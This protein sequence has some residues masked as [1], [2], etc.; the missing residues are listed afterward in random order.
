MNTAVK[1]TPNKLKLFIALA[2]ICLVFYLI[3]PVLPPII[4]A[5]AIAYLLDPIADFWEEHGWN[6]PM[7]VV[8]T[9]GLFILLTVAIMA[10]VIPFM[11]DQWLLIQDKL[12]DV[13][14]SIKSWV[15]NPQLTKFYTQYQEDIQ[16][17]LINNA[18]L[19]G[20]QV[21]NMLKET[22]GSVF[23]VTLSILNLVI[24][25]VLAIYLLHDFDRL[26]I[27]FLG[28][29]PPK[30]KTEISD[31]AQEIHLSMMG[32]IKA[33]LSVA[34]SLTV[35]YGIGL[36]ICGVPGGL[37]IAFIA[38]MANLIPYLGLVIGIVPA[39]LL[40][41]VASPGWIVPLGVLATFG[42]GQFL[43]GFFITPHYMKKSVNLHPLTVLISLMIWGH[44]L[45]L[46][47]MVLALPITVA[48]RVFWERGWILIQKT[49]LYKK[50]KGAKDEPIA[51]TED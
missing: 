42:I 23:R 3:A 18:S 14:S 36:T 27:D 8:A 9:I 51:T 21:L 31:I 39:L 33:Q 17:F 28:F 40:G 5:L 13:Q 6:R 47:G 35:I 48:L 12:P 10:Y 19:I 34:S 49:D 32:F 41:Y 22:F 29:M 30:W 37:L 44:L 1:I 45:G 11:S 7:A 4:I 50:P 20:K 46:W 25:P 16:S 38:G 43:E 2:L 26:R 24:I 15:E